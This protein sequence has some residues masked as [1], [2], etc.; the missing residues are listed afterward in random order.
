[1]DKRGD[2]MGGFEIGIWSSAIEQDADVW[3]ILLA[4]GK[5]RRIV[6]LDIRKHR[7]GPTGKIPYLVYFEVE[8]ALELSQLRD[9]EFIVGDEE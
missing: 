5:H 2:D 8:T 3:A 4:H 7:D 6:E 9:I 1:M